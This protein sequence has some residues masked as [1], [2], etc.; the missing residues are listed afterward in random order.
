MGSFLVKD[1]V[2]F[3]APGTVLEFLPLFVGGEED[4]GAPPRG[5]AF[6][7]LER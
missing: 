7:D 6:E 1:G 4:G 3:F 2:C 5:D